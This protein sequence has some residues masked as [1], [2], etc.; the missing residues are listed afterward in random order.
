M[1]IQT[2]EK[3]PLVATGDGRNGKTNRD[4]N[5]ELRGRRPLGVSR[6][7][8]AG[9]PR[10]PTKSPEQNPAHLPA[11]KPRR[12]YTDSTWSTIFFGM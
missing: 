11:G 6:S 5:W 7:L 1:C 10:S 9:G 2:T 8:S 3:L 12:E 4:S